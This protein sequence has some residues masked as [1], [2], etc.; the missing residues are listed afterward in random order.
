VDNKGV[1]I[2]ADTGV[3][4]TLTGGIA[5][6]NLAAGKK[7]VLI[8]LKNNPSTYPTPG[9]HL[10]QN[11]G[12]VRVEDCE[13]RGQWGNNE[14]GSPN[15]HPQGWDGALVQYCDDVA[16]VR[17][18]L[19]GGYGASVPDW[20]IWYPTGDGGYGLSSRSSTVACYDCSLYGGDGGDCE[21]VH[22]Y[23]GGMGGSGYWSPDSWLFASGSHFEGGDGGYGGDYWFGAAG[24]GGDGG[25]GVYLYGS[26]AARA[27]LLDNTYQGGAGGAGGYGAPNGDPGVAGQNIVAYTGIAATLV[28]TT[29]HTFE[30]PSPVR[31]F[32][33]VNLVFTGPPGELAAAFFSV[34]TANFYVGDLYGQWLLGFSPYFQTYILGTIPGSGTLTVPVTI[35]DL[36]AGIPYAQVYLQSVFSDFAGTNTLGSQRSLIILDSSY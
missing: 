22:N 12:S 2:V 14:Y 34:D 28:G 8:G 18:E 31:E 10:L 24:N 35:P 15:Y 9:L 13:F 23:D 27:W 25:H 6:G 29:A 3:T 30:M 7:V 16:F 36:G 33:N 4:V 11:A 21:D 5:V 17:C 1:A 19:F 20:W 32:Q 26:A